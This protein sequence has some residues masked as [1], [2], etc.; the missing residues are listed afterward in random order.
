[1]AKLRCGWIMCRHNSKNSP[2]GFGTC[3]NTEK[4][5]LKFK[6]E[7]EGRMICKQYDQN[8]DKCR[9]GGDGE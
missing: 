9:N 3:K 7:E 5:Y 8:N 6:D 1:M 4:V 2:G